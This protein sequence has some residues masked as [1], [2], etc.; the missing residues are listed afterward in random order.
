MYLTSVAFLLAVIVGAAQFTALSLM[1]DQVPIIVVIIVGLTVNL[2]MARFALAYTKHQ[3]N[4]EMTLSQKLSFYFGT[5]GLVGAIWIVGTG[6]G[7]WV[8][9]R[10]PDWLALDF[11]IPIAFIAL[12]APALRIMPQVSA[13]LTGL[14]YPLHSQKS[15]WSGPDCCIQ[16]SS[17]ARHRTGTPLGG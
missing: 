3:K 9:T 17:S 5:T 10:I 6:I 1:L 13:A 15:P 16:C 12:A 8:G 4:P 11:A 2:R 14:C 7:A